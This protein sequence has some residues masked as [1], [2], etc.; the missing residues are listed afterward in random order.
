MK[1]P[2]RFVMVYVETIKRFNARLGLTIRHSARR[3][4]VFIHE[5]PQ[6]SPLQSARIACDREGHVLVDVYPLNDTARV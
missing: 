4:R 6:L 5:C 2:R 1:D 3:T